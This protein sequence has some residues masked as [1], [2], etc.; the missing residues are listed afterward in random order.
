MLSLL[1][2]ATHTKAESMLSCFDILVSA[3]E[4]DE[5]VVLVC[6]CMLR[7]CAIEFKASATTTPH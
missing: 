1:H 2:E 3:V 5:I 7:V 6:T 4:S